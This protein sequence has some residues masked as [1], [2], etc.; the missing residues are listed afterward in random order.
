LTEEL[1][2]KALCA[3]DRRPGVA[4]NNSYTIFPHGTDAYPFSLGADLL[5]RASLWCLFDDLARWSIR[6]IAARGTGPAF[7]SAVRLAADLDSAL[8]SVDAAQ[9]YWRFHAATLLLNLEKRLAEEEKVVLG[10]LRGA[11]GQRNHDALSRVWTT[12][13]IDRW[14]YVSSLVALVLPVGESVLNTRHFGLLREIMHCAWKQLGLPVQL[15]IPLVLFA[16]S[17]S[18]LPAEIR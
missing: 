1:R 13:D 6:Q 16:W 8:A 3:E 4:E 9:S 7:G 17:R 5:D 14:P 18:L 15:H 2:G 11:V 12:Q 10:S